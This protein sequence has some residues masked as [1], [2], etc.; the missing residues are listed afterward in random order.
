MHWMPWIIVRILLSAVLPLAYAATIDID[1]VPALSIDPSFVLRSYE[2]VSEGSIDGAGT[3]LRITYRSSVPLTG[4]I[5]P[6]LENRSYRPQD[7]LMF[8]LPAS[9]QQVSAEIDLT[10]SSSWSPGSRSYYLSFLSSQTGTDTQFSDMQLIARRSLPAIAFSHLLE[11]PGFPISS[12]HFLPPYRILG[13]S[14]SIILGVTLLLIILAA[15]VA[16]RAS[17]LFLC[18]LVLCTFLGVYQARSAVDRLILSVRHVGEWWRDGTYGEAR[19]TYVIGEHILSQYQDG[20]RIGVC[21]DSSD[22]FAKLLRYNLYPIPVTIGLHDSN[23]HALT[24]RMTTHAFREGM[25]HC[26][27][28][29]FPATLLQEYPDG[30]AFYALSSDA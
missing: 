17:C 21:F 15:W 8:T 4:F 18:T 30:S 9:L 24:I 10:R 22:Y 29:T 25:L 6:F 27:N 12:Y 14:V 19:S 26:G 1:P 20:M 28:K 23:T 3:H 11:A 5:A 2:E 7:L 13:H 16:R